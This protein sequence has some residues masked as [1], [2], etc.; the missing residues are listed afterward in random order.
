MLVHHLNS[1]QPQVSISSGQSLAKKGIVTA[2]VLNV[3]SQGR[4][5]YTMLTKV[6]R[7]TEVTLL[8]SQPGWYKVEL[9]NGKVG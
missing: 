3:R 1:D 2:S 9:A 6:P 7:G 4:L 8:G 5:Q